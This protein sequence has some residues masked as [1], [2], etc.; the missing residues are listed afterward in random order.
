M[1][2]STTQPFRYDPRKELQGTYLDTETGE[3]ME[4]KLVKPLLE[5]GERLLVVESVWNKAWDVTKAAGL[6]LALGTMAEGWGLLAAGSVN[7]MAL[8]VAGADAIYEIFQKKEI[9]HGAI[10]MNYT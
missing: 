10:K 5:K 8:I 6:A 3:T 4:V 1:A 7:P 9:P 2:Q